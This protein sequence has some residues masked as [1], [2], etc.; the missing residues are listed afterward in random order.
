M[1]IGP[2]DIENLLVPIVLKKKTPEKSQR[3]KKIPFYPSLFGNQ[4]NRF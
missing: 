1:Q 2:E 4:L 3:S